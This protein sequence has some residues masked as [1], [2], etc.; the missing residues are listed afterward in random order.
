MFFD[1]MPDRLTIIIGKV[2]TK[3]APDLIYYTLLFLDF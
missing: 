3:Q 1:L 2:F